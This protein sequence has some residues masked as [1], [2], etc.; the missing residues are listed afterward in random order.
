MSGNG[1]YRDE[2]LSRRLTDAEIEAIL[3]DGDIADERLRLIAGR[4]RAIDPNVFVGDVSDRAA[5]FAPVAARYARASAPAQ[6]AATAGRRRGPSL[7]PRLVTAAVAAILFLGTAG[8]AAAS[9]SAVP[10]SPL[11]GLDRA[12]E[13]VGIGAGGIF[14]RIDEAMVLAEDGQDAEALDLLAESLESESSAAAEALHAA[15]ER[16]RANSN[17]SD[18]AN[19]VR[20]GVAAILDYIAQNESSGSEFGQGVADRA[21]EL[22]NRPD[23][24]GS[25]GN[26]PDDPGNQGNQPDDP[27]NQGNQP[28]DPGNQGN[29]GQGNQGQ[30]NQGQGN[31]P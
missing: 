12:L 3:N 31:R 5:E 10:G 8:A 26:R 2:M 30:G 4:L 18:N 22:G 21:R 7:T 15:A 20:A 13:R 16:I 27:G 24:P 25:Q 19:S 14:E 9:D 1:D 29:Q 17:G 23:D 6:L 28:D 11:Y